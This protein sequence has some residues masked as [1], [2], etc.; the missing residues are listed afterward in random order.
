MKSFASII[1]LPLLALIPFTLQAHYL[2]PDNAGTQ[3]GNGTTYYVDDTGS[4]S[5]T[6]LSESQA[7]GTINYALNQLQAGDT[8][9]VMDGTYAEKLDR[10]KNY[11]MS[12]SGTANDY[13]VI[14]NYPGHSPILEVNSL[15]GF[16]TYQCSYVEVRGLTFRGLPDPASIVG[17]PVNSQDRINLANSDYNNGNG[18]M[19]YIGAGLSVF[20]SC[21][22]I[23]FINNT[24]HRVGGNGINIGDSNLV[25]VQGNT[26]YNT[27]HRSTAGNSGISAIDLKT[28]GVTPQNYGIVLDGNTVYDCINLV[29][30]SH[31]NAITDGN[32]I[33]LD[34]V[35]KSYYPYRIAVLN[36]LCYYN[37]GRGIHVYGNDGA[38]GITRSARHVDVFNNTVYHNLRTEDFQQWEADLSAVNCEDVNFY[39]NISVPVAGARAFNNFTNVASL[40][41]NNNLLVSDRTD[42][43]ALVD[44]TNLM[45]SDPAFVNPTTNPATADFSL[46]STSD[47]ID[48]ASGSYIATYDISAATRPS[49]ADIGAY[50]YGSSTPP[51]QSPYGGTAH[52]IPGNIIASSYDEGGEGI[53]YHDN[54]GQNEM[55]SFRSPYAVDAWDGGVGWINNGEWLEFTVD[56]STP[57]DYDLYIDSAGT[58]NMTLSLSSDGTPLLSNVS[59]PP[60]TG[61][62]DYVEKSI[63]TVALTAG[64]QVLRV[65]FNTGGSNVKEFRLAAASTLNPDYEAWLQNNYPT[66]TNTDTAPSADPDN[67]GVNNMLEYALGTDPTLES[68]VIQPSL[69]YANGNLT[70][71]F[72]LGQ[73]ASILTYTIE[74]SDIPS[75]SN[76]TST[77]TINVS[78]TAGQNISVPVTLPTNSQC[79]VRLKVTFP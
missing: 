79:Y 11:Q 19:D 63:G 68:S 4:D 54:D 6:G 5:N 25:L 65:T 18:P 13:I 56:V 32:G 77:E 72:T 76:I 61:W 52:S 44:G 37:G 55:G 15:N 12:R 75:F 35:Y 24:I 23:R 17:D 10:W 9:Y 39:N 1:Y 31:A 29:N 27:S 49:P 8:L 48:A 16:E 47:A 40:T 46:Q 34:T 70:F 7:F 26:V 60:T 38:A 50:E 14:A 22:N 78:Y 73:D 42:H 53:A 45:N 62:S 67:D 58:G 43:S 74:C 28:Q 69:V 41:V 2:Q 36:N 66:L 57:G 21:H 51:T 33:I 59:V 30:N 3:S 64:E 71:S 20:N